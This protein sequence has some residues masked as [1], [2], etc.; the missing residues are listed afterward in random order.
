MD[1]VQD[2]AKERH[3]GADSKM[4]DQRRRE[5]G[6]PGTEGRTAGD[7]VADSGGRSGGGRRREQQGTD[8][9]EA[10]RHV[11][12]ADTRSCPTFRREALRHP[13]ARAVG[14]PECRSRRCR[15]S[16][17][18]RRPHSGRRAGRRRCLPRST[19]RRHDCR[20]RHSS[21]S[22]RP[23]IDASYFQLGFV[24]SAVVT[25]CRAASWTGR[26]APLVA[27]SSRPAPF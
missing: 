27:M 19:P 18:M 21:H 10:G 24:L 23:G 9:R 3:T 1:V 13:S 22:G 11:V 16:P 14:R 4:E 2:A 8:W 6:G 26:P 25:G 7:G 5:E 12:V 17:S 15:S 20:R